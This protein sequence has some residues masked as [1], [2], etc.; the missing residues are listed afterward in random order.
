MAIELSHSDSA[1]VNAF[2]RSTTATTNNSQWV[3]DTQAAGWVVSRQLSQPH[4][5]LLHS[6][7]QQ[8]IKPAAAAQVVH[9]SGSYSARVPE[10]TLRIISLNTQYW[11]KQKYEHSLDNSVVLTISFPFLVSGCMTATCF[12]KY[13]PGHVFPFIV[14]RM[15]PIWQ[16]RPKW[17]S[18]L[19]DSGAPSCG[20]KQGECLDYRAYSSWEEDTFVDQVRI[21]SCFAL[22]VIRWTE[23][24]VQPTNYYD[25]ILQRYKE[26]DCGTVFRTWPL[27]PP[28]TAS[29][30]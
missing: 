12:S 20:R 27:V 24:S 7:L 16:A 6:P 11:Y 8:W 15:T 21:T 5:S 29:S 19:S 17:C 13:E 2:A 10:T 4:H 23:R 9:Q 25:Q 18:C 26:N 22:P 1:P 28:S 3:F 30:N 14:E